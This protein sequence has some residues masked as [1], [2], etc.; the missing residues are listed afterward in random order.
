M[1]GRLCVALTVTS[2]YSEYINLPES[3][4]VPVPAGIDPAEAASRVLNM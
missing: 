4:L 2:A 1:N 3:Q